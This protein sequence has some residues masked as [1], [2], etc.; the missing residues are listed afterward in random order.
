MSRLEVI[1]SKLLGKFLLGFHFNDLPKDILFFLILILVFVSRMLVR[2]LWPRCPV[3]AARVFTLLS[4]T[5]ALFYYSSLMT[6]AEWVTNLIRMR[7]GSAAGNPDGTSSPS[8]S[9]FQGLS[10]EIPGAPVEPGQEV[11]QPEMA[12]AAPNPSIQPTDRGEQSRRVLRLGRTS[13]RTAVHLQGRLPSKISGLW[14]SYSILKK[15]WNQSLLVFTMNWGRRKWASCAHLVDDLTERH[16]AE[17]MPEILQSFRDPISLKF[18]RISGTSGLLK[19][20][21]LI[22]RERRWEWDTSEVLDGDRTWRR[23]VWK[24]IL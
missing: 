15:N 12:L 7:G 9:F 6:T 14:N 22:S 4:V 23:K 2:A 18:I 3:W 1:C 11:Q 20:R 16:G 19:G 10:R 17:K 21:K 24:N 5:T 13:Q 8:S